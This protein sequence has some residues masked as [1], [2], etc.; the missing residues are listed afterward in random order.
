LRCG[1]WFVCAGVQPRK[2]ILPAQVAEPDRQQQGQHNQKELARSSTASMFFL[3]IQEV[4]EIS[5]TR[6]MRIDTQVGALA[7]RWRI[8]QPKK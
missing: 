3:V 6:M 7:R 2:L 1:S 4:I 8:V 5:P